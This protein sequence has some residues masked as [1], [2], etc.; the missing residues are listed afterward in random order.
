MPRL[1]SYSIAFLCLPGPCVTAGHALIN[2]PSAAGDWIQL[3]VAQNS[4]RSHKVQLCHHVHL[5]KIIQVTSDTPGS[6]LCS[7]RSNIFSEQA[8]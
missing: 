2:M 4:A 3:D 6:F 7:G 8:P 1:A 5:A